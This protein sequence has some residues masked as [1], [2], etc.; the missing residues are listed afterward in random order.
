MNKSSYM[1]SNLVRDGR[2][3]TLIEAMVAMM[4]LTIGIL[5]VYMMQIN[6]IDGNYRS[7]HVTIASNWA[8]QRIEQIISMPYDDLV[9]TDGDGTDQ[10]A[11][12]DGVDDDTDG[13]NDAV[14][15][16]FGLDDTTAATADGN[17]TS[18]DGEY[19]IFWNIADNFPVAGV[20]TIRVHIQDSNPGLNNF[21]RNNTTGTST[22]SIVT[23]QYVKQGNI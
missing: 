10:D 16:N 7:S 17:A 14:D 3:F 19:T 2:G 18:P 23:M 6:A 8:A 22:N 12:G 9:D 21:V 4:V 1:S 13:V 20:R 15:G 11:D 5:A